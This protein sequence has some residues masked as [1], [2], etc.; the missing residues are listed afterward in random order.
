MTTD[1]DLTARLAQTETIAR[2]AGAR[3]CDHFRSRDS[4]A[5][6]TKRSLTDM[7][8]IADR[9]VETLIREELQSAFPADAMLGEEYGHLTG[10]SGLTWVVDPIDGTAPFLNGL[11][12]WCVSI[13]LMDDKGPLLGAI[14]APVLGEMFLG[15]RGN[16]ASLNGQPIQVTRRFDLSSGLLGLGGNDR[17]PPARLGQ[18]HGELAA[19]GIAWVR[20]GSGAL[21][22]AYVAAGR[23]VGY[24][25]P[26]MSL[27]DC[28][29]AYA[30]IEAAGGKVLPIPPMALQGAPFGVMGTTVADYQ[31]LAA[32]T[33]FEAR[34]WE[35]QDCL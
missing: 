18:L 9:E 33:R 32:L 30:L 14:F 7:V 25:E 28:L 31:R 15:A 10:E 16:G 19:E 20:Y 8:S 12:G 23:L 2:L 35:N 4:L 22:L 6:E 17:V 26:R 24:C 21:M 5:I 1:I 11:P 29:A 3:A 13:G 34:D 27:W